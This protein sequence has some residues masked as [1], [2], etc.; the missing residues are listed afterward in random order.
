MARAKQQGIAYAKTTR[1][2]VGNV[3]RREQLFAR[4][5]QTAGWTVAWISGP[6]GAGKSTL[7][8][9]YVEARSL[10]S[11]WY[12]I[13]ADD[14]DIA[15]F[16]HYLAHAARRFEGRK[17]R[18]LP[19]FSPQHAKDVAGFS[20]R[21]F[22]QLFLRTRTPAALV[23]D[24][25]NAVA[26]GS[27]LY[28][29]IE[30]GLTQV[31]GHCRI[32]VT[33]RSEPPGTL[34]R[35]RLSGG[36][37][38]IGWEQLRLNAQEIADIAQL[39]GQPLSDADIAAL[40]QRTQGWA[41]GLVLMLEH[42]K[43]A[44]RLA[45]LPGDSG[46]TVMF[47][48]L[49]GEIFARFDSAIQQFLLRIACLPRM[50]AQVAAAIAGDGRAER[51]LLNMARND[52]FVNQVSAENERVFQLHP[53]LRDFLRNRATQTMPD[54]V[55]A[56]AVR[57]A[58]R[59]LHKAGLIDDA[60]AVLA[61]SRDWEEAAHIIAENAE[62]LLSQDR[63]ETLRNW[64]ELLP[65]Q[66]L[67]ADPR[68]LC[69]HADSR[70][71]TSTRLA[72]RQYAEAFERYRHSR[73]KRGMI[74]SC[75]GVISAIILEFDDL[76]L[77]DEWITRLFGL[78]NDQNAIPDA[79]AAATLLRALM[80][81]GPG[82]HDIE[83][84]LDKAE[85]AARAPADTESGI[86]AQAEFHLAKAMH[87]L[88]RGTTLP[89]ALGPVEG[90]SDAAIALAV[91]NSLG[92]LIA[93]MPE[94]AL[95]LVR[96][97]RD[98]GNDADNQ[99]YAIW[100][101]MLAVAVA[102]T[103]GNRGAARDELAS[104]ESPDT[105]LRRGDQVLVHYLRG[106]LA[107]LESDTPR[108]GRE[109]RTALALADELGMPWAGCLTRIAAAQA[110]SA[111]G[112]HRS[113]NA[114]LRSA[115]DTAERVQNPVLLA[116]V[117]LALAGV[118]LAAADTGSLP[119]L[120]RSGLQIAREQSLRHFIALRPNLLA[121]VCAAAMRTGVETAFAST[122]ARASALAPPD[123]ATRL[124][125]WPR[126]IHIDM[127]GCFSMLREGKPVEFS[128]KGPGRPM[129]LLKVLTALGAQNVRSD[130]LADALWPRVDADYAHKSFT[131]TLH[132]LRRMLEEDDALVLRDGR[133]SLNPRLVWLDVWALDQLLDE[134]D[135]ALREPRPY[136]DPELHKLIDE[137]L[138]LYRGPFLPDESE[139]PTYIG[140]R[141]RL[142]TKLLRT[143]ARAARS[144]E[145]AGAQETAEDCYARIID[146]DPLFEAAYRNL[147]LCYQRLGNVAELR[148]TY[149]RLCVTLAARLKTRP[150]AETDAIIGADR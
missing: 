6:A 124:R 133:L 80:L 23:L 96:K 10:P 69:A 15:T 66:L 35:L 134:I 53:L 57:H 145:Q 34:A 86:S 146:S 106:W 12:Q 101:R 118:S 20:R 111:E 76:T 38:H 11:I 21:F 142:R 2:V 103:N 91:T 29:A 19:A 8:A 17:S 116:T 136:P 58:A 5:D 25:L 137:L 93:G 115:Q 67:S 3:V 112:D 31:P 41:A 52:Y 107:S 88:L 148:A 68:L 108:A 99:A 141:E 121:E 117:K 147:M 60:V 123:S 100:L 139:Q 50:T 73:D 109:L 70:I 94:E 27:A 98:L 131:I 1:P 42:A 32:L 43:V 84:L 119:A 149:E 65:A 126:P 36:L 62:D 125:Q 82:S 44:G 128:G 113:A 18:D 77:L 40:D 59:E 104:I 143:V 47:D 22:R 75:R 81:R 150:S 55:S 102:L 95:A 26:A 90:D 9:S 144:W 54:A 74:R 51:I 45:E 120:L 39:R 4:L 48:Y 64:L 79:G 46:P 89:T 30:A 14:A 16:F 122:L 71:H 92:H 7:A 24:N 135:N 78:V 97:G 110:V 56:A 28:T 49:A 72:R 138:K 85:R 132:R 63:G 37:L 33:S 140:C 13:D 130:H 105:P 129:E 87:G 61:E 114:L 127:L 83:P